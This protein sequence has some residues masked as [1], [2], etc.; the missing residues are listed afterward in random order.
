MSAGLLVLVHNKTNASFGDFQWFLRRGKR[1][2]A[3]IR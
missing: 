1:E 2:S 3:S